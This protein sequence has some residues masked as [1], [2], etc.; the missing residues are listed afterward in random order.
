MPSWLKSLLAAILPD[1]LKWLAGIFG[2]LDAPK[3]DYIATS[4]AA[5]AQTIAGLHRV[6]LANRSKT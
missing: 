2:T 4:I 5:T 1:V 3:Q 6:A